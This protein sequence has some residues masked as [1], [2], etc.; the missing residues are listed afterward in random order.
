L[1][2]IHAHVIEF[3]ILEHNEL[4]TFRDVLRANNTLRKRYEQSK[5]QIL[6][7]G[8][9]DSVEYSKVKGQFIQDVLAEYKLNAA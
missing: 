1:F 7:S 9:I 5:R 6:A 4:T 3:G 2:R 8:V